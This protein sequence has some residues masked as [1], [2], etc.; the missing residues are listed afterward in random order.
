MST[1]T[2]RARLAKGRTRIST[3]YDRTVGELVQRRRS[4]KAMALGKAAPAPE[5]RVPALVPQARPAG[6]VPARVPA[7]TQQHTRGRTP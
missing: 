3:A 4:R 6:P 5:G 1:S 7:R 2:W